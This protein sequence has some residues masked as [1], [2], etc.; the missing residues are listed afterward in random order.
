[1]QNQATIILGDSRSMS[2]IADSQIDL[3]VTS[4]PYWHLKIMECLARL[5]MAKAFMNICALCILS[6]RSAF[7]V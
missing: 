6:G 5:D 7:E 2:E 3:V 1:M 4:P